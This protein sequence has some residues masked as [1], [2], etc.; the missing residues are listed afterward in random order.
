M[1]EQGKRYSREFVEYAVGLITQGE[2]L[3]EV[4]KEL[5]ID[6]DR[7]FRWAI[8]ETEKRNL[9]ILRNPISPHEKTDEVLITRSI[10]QKLHTE[11]K[12]NAMVLEN[13][14]FK[15]NPEIDAQLNQF[16]AN[17]DRLVNYV[18]ALPREE[19]ERKYLL[20]KMKDEMHKKSYEKKVTEYMNLPENTAFKESLV[21]NLSLDIKD[22]ATRQRA[23]L[24]E[25]KI[26]IHKQGI[27]MSM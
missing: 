8:M 2:P 7:L 4:A 23:L 14:S 24:K 16:I 21:K 22:E 6:P 5:K 12:N 19:V 15:R 3:Y 18:K 10:D 26:Q 9:K 1:Q 25:E 27:K 11:N 13:K 20:F 17:N